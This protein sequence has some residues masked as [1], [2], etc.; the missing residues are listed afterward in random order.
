V[1]KFTPKEIHYSNK[2][3]VRRKAKPSNEMRFEANHS[4]A[5]YHGIFLGGDDRLQL[6]AQ[7]ADG[8]VSRTVIFDDRRLLPLIGHV[9]DGLVFYLHGSCVGGGRSCRNVALHPR[10]TLGIVGDGLA[11]NRK[12][13]VSLTSH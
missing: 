8:V 2:E 5:I 11:M 3:F 7:P 6:A 13:L 1:N 9:G 12:G 10:S 4:G